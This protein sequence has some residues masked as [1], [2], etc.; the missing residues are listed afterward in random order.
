[1]RERKNLII[2]REEK[3]GWVLAATRPGPRDDTAG[4]RIIQP[5]IMVGVIAVLSDAFFAEGWLAT[6]PQHLIESSPPKSMVEVDG[7]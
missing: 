1:M 6:Q 2:G 5:A 7:G 4:A 3:R